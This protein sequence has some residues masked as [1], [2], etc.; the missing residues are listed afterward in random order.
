MGRSVVFSDVPHWNISRTNDPCHIHN[1]IQITNPVCNCPM[2]MLK[3][4]DWAHFLP[5]CG[6]KKTGGID[7]TE[8]AQ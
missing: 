7:Y 1:E 3:G 2:V 5:L 8:H 4:A 6:M